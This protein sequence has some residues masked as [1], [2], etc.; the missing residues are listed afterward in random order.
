M[1]AAAVLA[2][3]AVTAGAS[4]QAQTPESAPVSAPVAQPVPK[5]PA[6]K[7][8]A[9]NSQEMKAGQLRSTGPAQ[10]RSMEIIGH[11]GARDLGPEN[12]LEAIRAAFRTGADAVE[13]DVNFTVDERLVLLH[14]WTLDRTT[15]CT[16]AVHKQKWAT[17]SKCR[18][19]NGEKLPS[20]SAAL[21]EVAKNHG[22]AYIHIKR[23]DNHRQARKLL[24]VI[25]KSGLGNRATVIASVT[26]VLDRLEEVGARRLG[27]VFNTAAGWRTHYPVLVPFNVKIT[28]AMVAK[29]QRRGQFVVAVESRPL[30]VA[31]LDRLGLNGFMAN[32]LEH[33]MWKLAGAQPPAQERVDPQGPA[34]AAWT[35][36]HDITADSNH[37]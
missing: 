17:I 25:R 18:T 3:P 29:A 26:P 22:K 4:A 24:E 11:R 5:Q 23:T 34:R 6:T 35:E 1:L 8:A 37:N 27:Y 31:D 12:T 19:S 2:V 36:T 13:F 21:A 7:P 33:S 30:D 14:D 15:N 16:G 32:H 10:Y 9:K 28:P 20:L